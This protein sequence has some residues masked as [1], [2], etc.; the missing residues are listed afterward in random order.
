LTS[1]ADVF[2][3]VNEGPSPQFLRTVR[4]LREEVPSFDAYPFSLP[5]VRELFELAFHPSVTY[6]VGENGSGKSTLLEAIAVACGFNPEGGSKNFAFSTRA[7]HSELHR[8]LRVSRGYKRPRDGYFLRAESFYN[9]A[10]EIDR[11]DEEP[12]F[13]PPIK[14]YYGGESLHA[15]SHG[16]SFMALLTKRIKGAGL[17]IFDEPEAALSPSRQMAAL[18]RLHQLVKLGAQFIIATHSPILMAYPDA[19]IY[20]L[21]GETIQSVSYD[22]TEHFTVTRDFLNDHRRA[23]RALMDHDGSGSRSDD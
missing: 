6:V 2:K 4:L 8:F 3:Q 17:Y 10:S 9:V 15:Q 21:G 11:L 19:Q 18:V 22:E 20:L 14:S 1:V 7:S 16:E 13:S 5:A 12:A 23:M